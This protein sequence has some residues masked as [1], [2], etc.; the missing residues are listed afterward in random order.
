MTRQMS[1]SIVV[2]LLLS[3]SGGLMDAYSYLFR[4]EVFANAQTG[5]ILLFSV[6]LSRGQW[7]AALHY[8]LPVL[9]FSLGIGFAAVTRHLCR[10]RRLHW[11]QLCL[12]LEILILG[13]AAPLP[14]SANLLANSLIS[15][16]CG[17]QVESFRKVDGS[18][19]ATTMCI[20]NLRQTLH[21]LIEV[22]FTGSR[23]ALHA[24]R[25][26]LTVILAFALGAILGGILLPHLG[27]YTLWTI[28][29]LLAVAAALMLIRPQPPEKGGR[30]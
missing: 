28:V 17:A 8:L 13:L 2:G 12:L 29:G 1:E 5:N 7:L 3:L 18:T 4:G 15:L 20:G 22:G 6:Y 11:R 10:E 21:S 24:A 27:M 26:N 23:S 9:A 30:P 16:A 25:V 14:Q 19:A